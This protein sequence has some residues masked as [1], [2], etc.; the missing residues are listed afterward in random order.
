MASRGISG[1]AVSVAAIGGFL[2]YAGIRNVPMLDGLRE[3][4]QGKL[5][6]G[7]PNNPTPFTS[8]AAPTSGTSVPFAG[9]VGNYNLGAVKPHVRAVA[10]VVGVMFGIK[11]IYG[12]APGLFDHP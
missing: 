9:D 1:I 6:A 5:P 11:T 10:N 3:L 4:A 12:W 8:T 7:R 2:V